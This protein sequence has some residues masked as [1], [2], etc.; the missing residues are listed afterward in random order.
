MAGN[1]IDIRLQ[2]GDLGE[3]K[4]AGDALKAFLAGYDGVVDVLD[5]LRPGKPEFIVKL[6]DDAGGLGLTAKTVSEELR[7]IVQGNTGLEIQTGRYGVD[8]R[9]RLAEGTINSRGGINTLYVTAS[10]GSKIPLATVADI[11]ESRGYARINR[12]DGQ[13]TVSVIGA[14]RPTVVN[15]RELMME[16]KTRFAPELKKQFPGVTMAFNGQG[17]EARD[18]RRVTADQFLHRYGLCLHPAKLPVP[19]LYPA[20]CRDG[21]DPAGSHRHGDRPSSDGAGYL[22]SKPCRAGNPVP[23][24]WSTTRS[25][26]YPSSMKRWRLDTM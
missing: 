3:I 14:I 25:C 12:V 16:V 4:E 2:G 10:D 9:V 23:V 24:S 7:S 6:H 17:K 8:V 19:Q 13:R 21:R 26:L 1:A 20:I 15:A 22:H 5:D 11:T 18:N